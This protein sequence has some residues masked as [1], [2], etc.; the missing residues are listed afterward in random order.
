MSP[1][2]RS[3]INVTRHIAN[4]LAFTGSA[5]C[6][7]LS[8]IARYSGAVLLIGASAVCEACKF[9]VGLGAKKLRDD[10]PV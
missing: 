8:P 9:D 6:L 10:L 3:P 4:R 2:K 1:L 5:A 7:Y